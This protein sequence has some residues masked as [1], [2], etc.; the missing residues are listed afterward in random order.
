M[1]GAA[2]SEIQHI[3]QQEDGFYKRVAPNVER[4]TDQLTTPQ[5]LK[6]EDN[7]SLTAIKLVGEDAV[8][9]AGSTLGQVFGEGEH[10]NIRTVRGRFATVI[11]RLRQ[12]LRSSILRKA[13]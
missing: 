11:G 5:S 6:P 13:A 7:S 1:A 8:H 4:A 10:A 9:V 2:P 12:K 3:D